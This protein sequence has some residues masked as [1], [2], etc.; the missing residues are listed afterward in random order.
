[1]NELP[2]ASGEIR[3]YK[4][5]IEGLVFNHYIFE[6]IQ[7]SHFSVLQRAITRGDR[8]MIQSEKREE[9]ERH[10]KMVENWKVFNV[11]IGNLFEYLLYEIDENGRE[12]T[13][14]VQNTIKEKI[15]D[16]KSEGL[17]DILKR[18]LAEGEISF[19]E[20][21]KLKREIL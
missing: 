9:R 2:N 19:E 1:M 13:S 20:Y 16:S 18:R 21:E 8:E 6:E 3:V 10:S 7:S 4:R 15:T 12:P 5:K 14:R 11:T 17:M